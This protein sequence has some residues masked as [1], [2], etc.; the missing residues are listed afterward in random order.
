ML[1]FND[2]LFQKWNSYIKGIIT[3]HN[4][5]GFHGNIFSVQHISH[6]ATAIKKCLK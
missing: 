6:L 3:K 2:I 4:I 1:S 5:P